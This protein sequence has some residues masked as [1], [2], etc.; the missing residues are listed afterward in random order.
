MKSSASLTTRARFHDQGFAL[1]AT[2]AMLILLVVVAV[3]M[4]SLSAVSLRNSG[5][6]RTAQRARA[7]ARLA[8][9]LAIGEL[10]AAA[11]PDNRV[12]ASSAV[13]NSSRSQKHL[14]GVWEGWKWKGEGSAPD[15]KKEKEDRFKGW[16]V[17]SNRQDGAK[18]ETYADTEVTGEKVTLVEAADAEGKVVAQMVNVADPL[19]RPAGGF[20]WGVFDESQKADI[21]LSAEESSDSY[22][23]KYDRMTSAHELGYQS[24][25]DS[26][27]KV[28]S[29]KKEDRSKIL[30]KSQAELGGLE[31]EDASFH[32]VTTGSLGLLT[33]VVEGGFSKDVSTLF[34]A[35]ALPSS[36]ASRFI[37]SDKDTPLAPPPARFTG[38][39]PLPSPDPT[40]ALLRSH[41]RSYDRMS[42]GTRPEINAS[43]SNIDARP[44][45]AKPPTQEALLRHASFNRQQLAPVLAKAQFIFSLSFGYGSTLEDMWKAG[46]ARTSP[47]RLRDN[48]MTWL[49]IDPVITLWNPY[50][51]PIRLTEETIELYRIP[52]AFR[53]YKNGTLLNPNYTKLTN[54]YTVNDFSDRKEKYYLLK[55]LPETGQQ[56]LLLEPGEH[57]VFTAHN[58]KPH[59]DQKSTEEGLLLRPGFNPPAGAASSTEI[60]GI[61]TMNL[62]VDSN[63][64]KSGLDYGKSIRTV[65]VKAGDKI[66]ID[67]KTDRAGNDTLP[68]AGGREVTGFLKYY[69]G[70]EASKKLVG[71]IELDYG[72][73]EKEFLPPFTRH[74]LPAI[75]VDG[76]IP[77]ATLADG[78]APMRSLRWKEPFLIATFQQKTERDSRFPSRSWIN[79]APT[80]LYASAGLDQ[81]EEFSHQ[82]YELKWEPMF[83]WPPDSPTIEISSKRNR[84]YGGSGVY[85]QTGS[86]IAS[87]S[88][89]P[90]APA[91]SL[92]QFTHAPLNA[93]GQLPLT[94]HV[95]ANS[96]APPLIKADQVKAASGNRTYLDH[97]YLANNALL[98]SYFLSSAADHPAQGGGKA[99]KGDDLLKEFFEGGKRLPN[100]R[101]KPY[102]NT[103]TA[104]QVISRLKDDNE[105]YQHL[106]AN[107]LL[108]AP[109]NVNSTSVAAWEAVLASNNGEAA[110]R[111]DGALD[112]DDGL[113]VLRN[114]PSTGP[115]YESAGSGDSDSAKWTGYRRLTDKQI[116][117]LALKVVEEV[118]KRGPFQSLA[119][120]VNRRPGDGELSRSGALQSAIEKAELNRDVLDSQSDFTS[121]SGANAAAG[122]GNTADGA[123]GVITQ[124]D[125]LTPILPQLRARG[126]TFVIRAY[127]EASDGG[128]HKLKAWCEAT[129][130]RY[131]E[132]VDPSDA[133]SAAPVSAAN[134]RFG[135]RFQIVSFRWMSPTE[136]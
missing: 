63:G 22:E 18:K 16:L 55:I 88:S 72:D 59:G 67:V 15:W 27:W 65:A 74:E 28:L 11:G 33:D 87:F 17:S 56:S 36:Y 124:S 47:A 97:S 90:Q 115:S 39:N 89:L 135:R 20:A 85:A 45:A 91:H 44:D 129:V 106:A 71:G 7:N 100:S 50:N 118:K 68:E 53:L 127:G 125:L 10:Q 54:T 114:L 70:S 86:E 94:S 80:N 95:V 103:E 69:V 6:D 41:Y 101:F 9:Q 120:F 24:V 32:E 77:T 123:P 83:D 113:P 121:A 107:L 62:F 26:A 132:Y 134:K 5:A 34:D 42:S 76:A 92:G 73:K 37:Y 19:G 58:W 60:G 126:D 117:K 1:V 110:P 14:T 130:Q 64:A 98:D 93:G 111:T 46:S 109:F 116:E 43:V 78:L 4:L 128:G 30:S 57:M 66:E 40:W 23:N 61:T 49:V 112:E 31:K 105:V 108:E 75:V 104:R 13:G 136:I 8:L 21:A 131:P 84:G 119:E 122:S 99:R 52:L 81:T 35:E 133:A 29:E 79:N 48:Y 3:G 12:T 102:L 2:L 82:Q 51:V 25:K 96:F 38:A